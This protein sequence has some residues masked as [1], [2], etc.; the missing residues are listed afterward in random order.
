MVRSHMISGIVGTLWRL[1]TLPIKL[2]LLPYKILSV[3]ISA[4]I[5]GTIL[6]LIGALLVLFVL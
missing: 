6:L 3:L 1:I 2:L 4:I 5:Y